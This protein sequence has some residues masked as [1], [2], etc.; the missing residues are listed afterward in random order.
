MSLI[1]NRF[2]SELI[3]GAR[4]GLI[5]GEMYNSMYFLFKET[6][7][8]DWGPYGWRG[9]ERGLIIGCYGV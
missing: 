7:D 6:L 1:I 9:G 2:H 8:Y 3:I 5:F 4:W